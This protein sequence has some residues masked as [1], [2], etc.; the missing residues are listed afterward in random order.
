MARTLKAFLASG[1]LTLFSCKFLEKKI[2]LYCHLIWAPRHEVANQVGKTSAPEVFSS[3][4]F[5][6]RAK[7]EFS[8]ARAHF[9]STSVMIS[10]YGYEI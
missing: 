8:L 3:C 10:F 7:R 9:E 4:S 5:I 6:P 2:P 1:N